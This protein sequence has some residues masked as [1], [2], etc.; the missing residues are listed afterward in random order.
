M[1]THQVHF[2]KDADLILILENGAIIQHGTYDELANAKLDFGKLL[3][4]NEQ[5]ENT[6]PF[7]VDNDAN[8]EEDDIPYIDGYSNGYMPLKLKRNNSSFSNNSTTKSNSQLNFKQETIDE[9]QKEGGV[10]LRIWRKYFG[11]GGNCLTLTIF[12]IVLITSQLVTSGADYFVNYWTQQEQNRMVDS[13]TSTFTTKECVWI[14][15]LL[16]I[17]VIIV[18]K[19]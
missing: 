13:T 17:G 14:Y 8:D 11:S 7:V 9:E 2:L 19:Y 1:V 3:E 18:S 4:Q 12:V 15:G 10:A 6:S 5:K 16:I